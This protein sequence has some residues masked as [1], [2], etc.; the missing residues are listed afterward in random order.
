[1]EEAQENYG[2]CIQQQNVCSIFPILYLCLTLTNLHD[3]RY[4]LVWDETMR[5]YK[6][7]VHNEGWTDKDAVDIPVV[8]VHSFKVTSLH[9]YCEF[10]H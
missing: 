4:A 7:M 2:T 9:L 10:F 6:D 5:V 1:M 3:T 8:Q